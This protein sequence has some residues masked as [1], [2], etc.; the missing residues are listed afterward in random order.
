[1]LGPIL[2]LI[3]FPDVNLIAVIAQFRS[4]LFSVIL[5]PSVTNT[6]DTANNNHQHPPL[7]TPAPT[8][9]HKKNHQRTVP[10]EAHA[11]QRTE[12]TLA[13]VDSSSTGIEQTVN[14]IEMKRWT[15]EELVFVLIVI[16]IDKSCK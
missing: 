1:M 11:V 2:A 3:S 15:D 10:E 16:V 13:D 7:I 12:H 6:S 14:K 8:G 9:Q 5:V 4:K